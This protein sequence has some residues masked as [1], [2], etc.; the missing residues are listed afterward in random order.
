M[1]KSTATAIA[2]ALLV[3][4]SASAAPNDSSDR[5]RDMGPI[6]RI[7][8]IIKRIIVHPFDDIQPI[9]PIPH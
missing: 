5:G 1:R 7:I 3:T 9:Q 6:Q 8:R 2:F 4:I